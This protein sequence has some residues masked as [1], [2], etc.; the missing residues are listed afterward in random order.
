M[1]ADRPHGKDMI[2]LKSHKTVLPGRAE[3]ERRGHVPKA[4]ATESTQTDCQRRKANLWVLFYPHCFPKQTVE[5]LKKSA[6]N[7]H[8]AKLFLCFSLRDKAGEVN[9]WTELKFIKAHVSLPGSWWTLAWGP[10]GTVCC[11]PGVFKRGNSSDQSLGSRP[12]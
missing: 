11:A 10:V 7:Y 12:S 3:G 5:L 1:T 4:G 8:P 9:L 6:G 2:T